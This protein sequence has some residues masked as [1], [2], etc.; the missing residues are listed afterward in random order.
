M[1]SVSRMMG[2]GVTPLRDDWELR[3]LG[4]GDPRG[5]KPAPRPNPKATLQPVLVSKGQAP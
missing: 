2:R 1:A 3:F 4:R 5:V